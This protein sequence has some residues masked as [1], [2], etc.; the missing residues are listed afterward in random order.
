[1]TF[2]YKSSGVDTNKAE[3]I[4]SRFSQFQKQ[5]PK[6]QNLLSGIGP[7]ASCFS[8]KD[9]LSRFSDPVLV[10]SCDGVGT[11]L[12]LALDWG[13][14]SGLGQD[15][16]AM[17]VNDLLCVGATPLVFLDY[18]ACGSLKE[19]Q[20]LTLLKS[21]QLACELSDCSLAGGETAEMPGLYQE[22][23]FDLG[24]FVVGLVDR[25]NILGGDKIKPGD[26]VIAIESSGIHS[27]GFSLVRKLITEKNILPNDI[28][29]F[30]N[31]TWKETLLEP[32][33]IYA[34]SLKPVLSQL[35]G[36]AHIT[37]EGIPGNLPRILPDGLKAVL[38]RTHFSFPP[39]FSWLQKAAALSDAEMVETFN[40]GI[41]M[42]AVVSPS[43]SKI[44]TDHLASWEL[45]SWPIGSI[46]T[47]NQ[48][49]PTIEWV[50]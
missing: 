9:T 27:N 22:N 33:Q 17:N 20:L 14:L 47:S 12:K 19:E 15:L 36:L 3:H 25:P 32:T 2:T 45:N 49:E 23:D 13:D 10:T 48:N 39:L 46:E 7:F 40:C 28:T 34:R 1:M 8:L 26:T 6:N 43:Q 21:I 41:G 50:M 31:K 4:L 35:N 42:I 29:P 16:V 30:S 44:I 11:K 37:G 18:F 38:S 5:R 24:G